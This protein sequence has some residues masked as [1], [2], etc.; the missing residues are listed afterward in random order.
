MTRPVLV[1]H[2]NGCKRRIHA[3]DEQSFLKQK[4]R[5][6]RNCAALRL[7]GQVVPLEVLPAPVV[8]ELARIAPRRTL[9]ERLL[10]LLHVLRRA[11][12]G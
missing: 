3:P 11:V 4:H 1:T 8:K 2:C 6:M 5:H 12:F 10:V 9:W 7:H